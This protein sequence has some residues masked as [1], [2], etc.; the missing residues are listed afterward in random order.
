MGKDQTQQ[1]F[2]SSEPKAEKK[3]FQFNLTLEDNAVSKDTTVTLENKSK[4]QVEPIITSPRPPIMQ[5]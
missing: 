4:A 3:A 1:E 2:F 5:L